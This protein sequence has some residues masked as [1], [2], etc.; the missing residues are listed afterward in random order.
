MNCPSE[1]LRQSVFVLSC[2]LKIGA[3][4]YSP[5]RVS[6]KSV[7][8]RF[9]GV[10]LIHLTSLEMNMDFVEGDAM[11]AHHISQSAVEVLVLLQSI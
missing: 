9:V 6:Y 2:S 10:L 4:T 11:A 3:G 7:N 8:A 5:V 1:K